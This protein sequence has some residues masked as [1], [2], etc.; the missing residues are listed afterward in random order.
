MQERVRVG[1]LG[2]GNVGS[3]LVR[4]I[5]DHADVIEARAGVPLEVGGVAVRDLTNDRDL[6]LPATASPTTRR[7]WWP[8][9][10]ST[11][12]GGHRRHR[13]RRT[14]IVDALMAGQA[15]RHR[16]Q[17]APRHARADVVRDRRRRG[18]DFLFEASVGGGI[19]LIRP[20]R[21]SLAGDRIRRVD[22]H[23]ER[24]HQLHPDAHERRR[25]VV[26]RRA[27]GGA[28]ASA[29]PRP[30]PPPTSRASTPRR[31]ARSSR[32]SR[33]APAYRRRRVSRGHH[34]A[35]ARRHRVGATISAT[36]SS[37]SR[38]PRSSTARWRCASTRRW[39]PCAIRSP[40]C[41][42]RSTRC[43]SRATPSAS[44]CCT[45]A[46]PAAPHRVGRARRPRRR[47][48]E[49]GRG[50]QGRDHRGARRQTDPCDRRGVVAVLPDDRG[51]RPPGCARGDRRAVR[52]VRRVD[53]LDAA[54]RQ[55]RGSPPDLRH[56]QGQGVQPARTRVRALRDVEQVHRVGAGPSG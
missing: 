19:P 4:L 47:S 54:A 53:P 37:C 29:S 16:E 23:R 25:A 34:R 9:P 32:R 48:E 52:E 33:S 27:G 3:A 51:R 20:L 36:S 5:H 49:R 41:A 38:S 21:E 12:C 7:A 11:S 26:R 13:A 46:A 30:T 2:C 50:T 6:P 17:G 28:G 14:L 44:S 42:T 10:T 18:V 15:R 1:I 45:A 22:G 39:C 8:I 55:G 43:S 35:H 56:P 31:S 24:H 40:P